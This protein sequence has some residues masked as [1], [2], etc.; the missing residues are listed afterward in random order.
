MTQAGE[1]ERKE[2]TGLLGR[3]RSGHCCVTRATHEHHEASFHDLF[4]LS[5]QI[6]KVGILQMGN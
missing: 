2:D 1:G 6:F 5:L 4:C 3:D